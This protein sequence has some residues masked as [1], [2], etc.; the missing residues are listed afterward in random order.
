[1]RREKRREGT[2]SSARVQNNWV[3][4]VGEEVRRGGEGEEEAEAGEQLCLRRWR[5][6]PH[7]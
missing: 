1:M 4:G 7:W 5:E 2:V 6:G 3:R